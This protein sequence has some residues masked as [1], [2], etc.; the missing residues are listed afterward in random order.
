MLNRRIDID[1]KYIGHEFCLQRVQRLA[2]VTVVKTNELQC[3][4]KQKMVKEVHWSV[5]TKQMK[6]ELSLRVY[7]VFNQGHGI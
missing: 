7:E 3:K 2:R 6:T 5:M 4:I 1:I